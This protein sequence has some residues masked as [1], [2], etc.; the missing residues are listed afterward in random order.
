MKPSILSLLLF[1]QFLT[2]AELS[3]LHSEQRALV[4]FLVL[5]AGRRFVGFE[6]STFS[7]F[8][9]EWRYLHGHPRSSSAL[10]A[11]AVPDYAGQASVTMQSSS[12]SWGS[13]ARLWLSNMDGCGGCGVSARWHPWTLSA[14]MN[15][16]QEV[17]CSRT[18]CQRLLVFHA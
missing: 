2:A 1:P 3:G 7:L 15:V 14:V 12:I 18:V 4:D 5:A 8:V 10:V 11:A 13:R 9:R 16:L 17:R 6:E